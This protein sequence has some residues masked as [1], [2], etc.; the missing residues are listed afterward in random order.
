MNS[1]VIRY[2]YNIIFIVIYVLQN[3]TMGGIIT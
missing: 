3:T 1:D 2:H